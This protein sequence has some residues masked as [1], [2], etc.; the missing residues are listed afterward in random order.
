MHLWTQI[1]VRE[2]YMLVLLLCLGSGPASLLGRRFDTLSRVAMAP[3]L[4][5]CLGT[6]VFTTVL[7]FWPASSTY[8]LLP[9]L[10]L[11]SVAMAFW[12]GVS[13][14]VS[15]SS[16]ECSRARSGIVPRRSAILG[17]LGLALVAV[18]VLAPFD[19]TLH[20]RHSVGPVGYTVWDA[21][22]YAA[23]ADGIV[24][25]SIAE[26]IRPQAPSANLALG[27]WHTYARGDQNIDAA[28]LSANANEL[29]GLHA[30]ETQGLFLVVFLLAGALGAVA[31]VRYV[32]PA[33]GWIAPMAGALFAGPFF[34][35]LLADGSQA[36]VCGLGVILPLVLVAADSLRQRT[37]A[38]LVVTALLVSGLLA[39]Y[40][41]FVPGVA[42]A[43]A[44]VLLL[45]GA[46]AG[47]R[48]ALTRGS[49]AAAARVIA[50]TLS[51]AVAFNLV[52][53]LRDLRYWRGV[54]SG[55]YYATGLPDYHLPP[56]VIPGWLFQT[57][58]LYGLGESANLRQLLIG[59]VLP[60]VF[61][62]IV[63]FG[64]KLRPSRVLIS[65]VLVFVLMAAYSGATHHCSYCADRALLPVAPV[66][67][68]LLALGLAALAT[69]ASRQL[70]RLALA[71]ALLVLVSVALRGGEERVRFA[72]GAYY[73][74]AGART[75]VSALPSNAGAVEI[76]G[77]DE[78][79]ASAPGELPLVYLA[80]WEQGRATIS[81][82]TEYSNY[83][84][85]AY[86][87]G[88]ERSN[89]L[90]DPRYR[91]VLTRL[92]GLE[93]GRRVL[94]RAGP[95]ALEERRG[96]LDAT[97]TSGLGV[98]LLRLDANGLPEVEGPLEFILTGAG[99]A[100]AWISLRFRS[101]VHV[102]V[103]PQHGVSARALPG[104]VLLVCVRM[105]G[106]E[107]ARHGT[108]R[109]GFPQLAG[110]LPRE[111]FAVQEPPRGVQMTAMRGVRNC[112]SSRSSTR[113]P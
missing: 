83:L 20:E 32:A 29:V 56:S 17:G 67:I 11:A 65:L 78:S 43:V 38:G 72:N 18:V 31:C 95:L 87:N 15:G 30:T 25:Q 69:D 60:L 63:A 111:R 5:L 91:L 107:P 48:G 104:G 105:S 14:R 90:F 53:F 94:A 102:K 13:G 84:S 110:V 26:A 77:F 99:R 54:L 88:V 86:A 59:A 16:G 24:Q 96:P 8:W 4:G 101:V 57:N 46:N 62:A 52:S 89:P 40:P 47:R 70:R 34:L 50:A 81:L 73:L 113:S 22:G 74:E 28:P 109:L 21:A 2:L 108:L 55:G 64:F 7:W 36:A 100:P 3:V 79:P 80:A 75:L 98:S 33:P 10:A 106:P 103:P 66:A 23:E 61:A 68:A 93:T 97:V 12:R 92:G 9:I 58:E 27:Y 39:L 41:L 1:I 37:R 45:A 85:L 19:Y 49:L 42:L 51:L 112:R 76:E 6:C 35:Q 82:P 44:S 71:L